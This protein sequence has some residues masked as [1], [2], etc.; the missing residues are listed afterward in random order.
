MNTVKVGIAGLGRL[1]RVHAG[2]LAFRIPGAKLTAACSIVP[3]E[4]LY[5]Q[6]ELGVQEVYSD[7]DTMLAEADIDAVAIVTTSGLHCSQIESALKAG[8]HVFTE[9]PLGVDPEEC[10]IAEKAVEAHPD[11]VF[12]LGF[13]RRYD[14]SYRYAKEQIEKGVIGKPYLVK[15]TGIDPEALVEGSIKFAPTSGG[16]YIDMASHDV[17]LMRWFL[18]SE[19]VEVYALGTTFKHPEFTEC[20]DNETG[21]AIYQFANGAI[22]QL[23]VGRTAPH[24]Y[25]IETEIV[26]TEGTLRISPVPEKN[27]AMIYNKHGAVTECVSG[28]PER[29]A[30]AYRLEMQEFIDCIREGRKPDI[31]VYDGTRATEITFATARSL[32]NHSVERID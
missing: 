26:G 3:E 19:A 23:H 14:P 32:K 17:D 12:F 4:L 21:C 2:N 24:G 7:F 18:G 20:G 9:K 30:E 10:R 22:G 15:A 16:I 6:K 25:H 29:F 11:K 13:M 31:T 8:K 5:A 28:F 27:L 1:G